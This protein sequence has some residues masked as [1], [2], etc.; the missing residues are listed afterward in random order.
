MGVALAAG[1]FNTDGRMDLA[2]GANTYSSSTGRVYIFYNDGSIPT[3]DGTA[4]VAITGNGVVGLFG[5]GLLVGDFNTD[6]RTDLVV[7][8]NQHTSS[9]GRVYIFYNDG[10]FPSTV[11]SA[12]VTLIGEA[13]SNDFGIALAAGDFNAD[14]RMDLAIGASGY[15]SSNGRVYIFYNDGSMPTA[16]ASA[17]MKLDGVSSSFGRFGIAL[18]AADF[19]GD[20][21]VDLVVGASIYSPSGR[22]YI[23]IT[24]VASASS[25]YRSP[26]TGYTGELNVKGTGKLKGT[27]KIK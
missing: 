27:A 12:D 8:A 20:G 21:I 7:A 10:S 24:E 9:T 17:D 13:T 25:T 4:D 19:S 18:S 16:P 26:S 6:G 15:S 11:D 14:G 5:S 22:F 2:V 3:T 23:F 1:D